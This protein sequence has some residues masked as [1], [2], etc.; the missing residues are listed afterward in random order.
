M[1]HQQQQQK[2]RKKEKRSWGKSHFESIDYVHLFE[3]CILNKI[4]LQLH[5]W[6]IFFIVRGVHWR[7]VFNIWEIEEIPN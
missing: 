5:L 7:T 6:D 2:E 3:I 1:S 4:Y